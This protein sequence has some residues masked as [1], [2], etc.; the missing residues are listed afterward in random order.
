[1][2]SV[3]V[4][5]KQ[6][7]DV[8][9]HSNA[10]KLELAIVGGWQTV[11]PKG[12]YQPGQMVTFV[13][14]NC[15][16]PDAVAERWGIIKYLSSG[17]VR[18]IKLRGEPSYGFVVPPEGEPGR[19]IAE[20]LGILAWQP[21]IKFSVGD[22]EPAHP[23][24]HHYTDIEN[25]RHYPDLIQDGEEVVYTEKIH[26]TNSRIAMVRT[27]EGELRLAGSRTMQRKNTENSLYW[28]P[29]M[30][31]GVEEAMTQAFAQ[32]GSIVILFGEVYGKVQSLR[33][34][35][36]KGIG[37]AAFDLCIDGRFL[38]YDE[39]CAAT[40]GVQ[41]AAPIHRGPYSLAESARLAD[42]KS[43][44]PGADH[45]REGVVVRPVIERHDPKVGRV[46]LKYVSDAYLCGD[47]DASSE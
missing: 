18:A 22:A 10:D 28:S 36:D 25:M 2:S 39:F 40:E 23:L 4:T 19:N 15:I 35:L 43:T 11:V 7:D 9:P 5:T 32:C 30:A 41:K 24:F 46:I 14:P 34:G 45:I 1:M 3:I 44:I 6:I 16:V 27:P 26:G 42:G 38:N 12:Q 13:P 20:S 33:Y 37:Y 31:S 21:P 47:F 29:W 8:R 17:R